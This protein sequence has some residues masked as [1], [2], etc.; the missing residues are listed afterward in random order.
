MIGQYAHGNEPG[1]HVIYLYAYSNKPEK[2]QYYI[3]RVINEFHNN[4]ANGMIGNDDCGQMS[5]WYIFSSLGFYPVC[6]GSLQYVIGTPRLGK[7][8]MRLDSKKTFT[9]IAKNLS[10]ENFYIQSATLNGKPFDRS[11]ITHG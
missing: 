9:V 7:V 5:A 10:E 1:H 11:Y 6:P 8:V 4:T 2:G 3:H